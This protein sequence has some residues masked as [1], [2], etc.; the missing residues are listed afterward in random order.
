MED[1]TSD[2]DFY[3]FS[4]ADGLKEGGFI[5][6]R[7]TIDKTHGRFTWSRGEED[8]A[9]GRR[10]GGTYMIPR[11]S[12]VRFLTRLGDPSREFLSVAQRQIWRKRGVE[13]WFKT[14]APRV[15][16]LLT[17]IFNVLSLT[18]FLSGM[19]TLS[20]WRT[21]PRVNGNFNMS[22]GPVSEQL[23][24]AACLAF[25]T[26]VSA[27]VAGWWLGVLRWK[28]CGMGKDSEG[29][30]GRLDSKVA[31]RYRLQRPLNGVILSM[32]ALWCLC[33]LIF[34][35]VSYGVSRKTEC[36]SGGCVKQPGSNLEPTCGVGNCSCSSLADMFCASAGEN[37]DLSVCR[38][39]KQPLCAVKGNTDTASGVHTP[40]LA[41]VFG[42]TALTALLF[43]TWLVNVIS[44]FIVWII[45]PDERKPVVMIPQVQYHKFVVSFVSPADNKMTFTLSAE[46]DP[47][48]VAS[49]LMPRGSRA[50]GVPSAYNAPAELMG[51]YVQGGMG[52]GGLTSGFGFGNIGM[53]ATFD[54]VDDNEELEPQWC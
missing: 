5:T 32:L 13:Q 21:I 25:S 31:S 38:N 23:A 54:A 35:P 15:T 19:L 11:V 41:I 50:R 36:S 42:T 16:A 6:E 1:K 12:D 44:M 8:E 3:F 45:K 30:V 20:C 47:H 2:G 46:D 40:L 53:P 14:N 10:L 27:L 49:A 37:S 24:A 9:S 29:L 28:C 7:L 18:L 43:F 34:S 22:A 33:L 17:M 48:A 4:Y 52:F 51:G 26:G 39:V